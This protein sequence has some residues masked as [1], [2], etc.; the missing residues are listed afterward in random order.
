[1]MSLKFT[2]RR[3]NDFIASLKIWSIYHCNAIMLLNRIELNWTVQNIFYSMM[4]FHSSIYFV[5]AFFKLIIIVKMIIPL[6]PPI[7][8]FVVIIVF[9][10]LCIIIFI[11]FILPI[12]NKLILGTIQY[13]KTDW[14]LYFKR[15]YVQR[16][17]GAFKVSIL[18]VLCSHFHYRNINLTF[19]S[20][21]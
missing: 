21:I 10:S 3:V 15:S 20:L 9:L 8:I 18:A 6:I 7:D 12:I 11:I 13:R 17:D 14:L 4:P 5:T 1:M 16:K 2:T 19:D